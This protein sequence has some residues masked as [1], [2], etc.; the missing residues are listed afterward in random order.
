MEE[1]FFSW[2]FVGFRK[3]FVDLEFS[4]TS[5]IEHLKT[6]RGLMIFCSQVESVLKEKRG[7]AESQH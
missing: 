3:D 4:F 5:A 7:C 6:G 1:C 2:L